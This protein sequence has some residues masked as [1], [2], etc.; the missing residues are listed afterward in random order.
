M[1]GGARAARL[2]LVVGTLWATLVA[3][4]LHA[5][6]GDDM[7]AIKTATGTPAYADGSAALAALLAGQ[8]I[9]MLGVAA[10]EGA[11]AAQ[12]QALQDGIVADARRAGR[13]AVEPLPF[14][15]QISPDHVVFAQY[16]PAGEVLALRLV[17]TADA[18]VRATARYSVTA[19]TP[20]EAGAKGTVQPATVY[21]AM[22][23][24]GDQLAA[25]LEALP[26]SARYQRVAVYALEAQ[27]DAAREAR[28]GRYMQA[29]LGTALLDRGYLV[30]E[31]SKLGAV[32]EAR[33]D[34]A[35]PADDAG[36]TAIMEAL[37]AQAIVVGTVAD[38][39]A[40][41]SVDV[42]AVSLADGS[43]LGAAHADLPREGLIALSSDAIETRTPA[44]AVFRSLA[45]PGW[46]QAY[47][48]QTGKAWLV[49]AAAYTSL[50][51]TVGLG[52]A[53]WASMEAYAALGQGTDAAEFKAL[54]EQ[55]GAYAVGASIAGGVTAVLWT[56]GAIDA[57]VAHGE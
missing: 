50:A 31:R 27:G 29:A 33:A 52:V 5:R 4:V 35:V 39:G 37:D 17:R 44:E 54:R 1:K 3:P 15:G 56:A 42:R 30:V 6:P 21:G 48:G 57:Y 53:S 46:G 23:R 13:T 18:Q 10:V 7:P 12:A 2:G 24:L 11:P 26:G 36:R 8:D 25:R 47:N 9:G 32:L 38:A 19:H 14:D 40:R 41:F 16:I 20:G 34:Q 55:T 28:L 22:D 51:T 43:V 49:G 45:V